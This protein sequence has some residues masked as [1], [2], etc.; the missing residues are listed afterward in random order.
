M[1]RNSVSNKIF[2][3][4]IYLSVILLIVACVVPFLN[5]IALSLSSNSAVI[6]QQVTVFPVEW[7]I[8]TYQTVLRDSAMLY[9]LGYS[10]VLTVVYTILAMIVTILAAYPLTKQNLKGRSFFLLIMMVTMY[11]SGGIIPDYILV[12]D[13][14]LLNTTSSLLLPG[15]MSVYNMIILKSFFQ[16]LPE[17]LAEAA[18]IDGCNE[19]RILIRIILPLSLP[20]I[21][22]LSL[23]YAVS[24]WNTFMDALFYIT[25]PR[26]YPIQ[27]KLYQIISNS[28][29]LDIQAE[30]AI[31][32]SIPPESLKA[33]S[34][35]FATVPILVVY[36]WLQKYFVSG[37]MLGAVKG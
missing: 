36:P 22:T 37:V 1:H 23:F 2:D 21:A 12:K 6:S 32:S 26:L 34:V 25:S 15:L 31:G 7:T 13:L 33:A 11:F 28:Q 14:N 29:Q 4:I 3:S 20:A 35:V 27:L 17:S 16:S 10:I 24:R 8:D 5:I 9:S 18:A 19:L 30:G